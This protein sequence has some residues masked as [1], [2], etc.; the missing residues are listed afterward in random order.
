MEDAL[1]NSV[2]APATLSVRMPSAHRLD[3][4]PVCLRRWSCGLRTGR[5]AGTRTEL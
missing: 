4:R 1:I 5:A 2:H 3:R